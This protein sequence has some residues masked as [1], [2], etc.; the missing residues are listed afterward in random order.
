MATFMVCMLGIFHSYGEVA[1][2]LSDINFLQVHRFISR[3]LFY[4]IS[5]KVSGQALQV[6]VRACNELKIMFA[7]LRDVS[8]NLV[9]V[10]FLK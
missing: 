5:G 4:E 2:W 9:S 7:S 3:Y 6:S 8:F 1:G 10:E